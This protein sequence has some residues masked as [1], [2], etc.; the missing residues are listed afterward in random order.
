MRILVAAPS[1]TMRALLQNGV[2]RI[3]DSELV[4][5]PTFDDALAACE[6]PFDLAVVDRDLK[7]G[8]DWAWLAELRERACPQGRLI[9]IGTR[10]SRD[11]ALALRDLG[12]GAFLL[13]PLDPTRLTERA[14]ALLAMPLASETPSEPDATSTD[15]AAS[16]D[17][18][19]QAEA[20]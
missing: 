19:P 6:S 16:S 13:A 11:E 4:L 12:T 2:R 10:V 3:V 15:D 18:T 20:A 7:S 9:V 8:T 14:Q 5:C 17:D 1:A